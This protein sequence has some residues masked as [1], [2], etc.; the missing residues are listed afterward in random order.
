MILAAG[1]FVT[2]KQL[3]VGD[4][5]IRYKQLGMKGTGKERMGCVVLSYYCYCGRIISV[6]R[7]LDCRAGGRGFDS[8]DRN[9][10]QGLKITEK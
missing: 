4:L 7:A 6:G 8:R 10:T 2:F 9:N 1:N 5:V 3:R